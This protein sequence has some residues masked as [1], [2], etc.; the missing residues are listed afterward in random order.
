MPSVA[1]PGNYGPFT[2]YRHR[3]TDYLNEAALAGLSLETA[4]DWYIDDAK[5]LAT[6]PPEGQQVS[7]S[8]ITPCYTCI[9]PAGVHCRRFGDHSIIDLADGTR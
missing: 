3:Y 7:R 9:L 2:Y 5:P 1:I 4:A 8:A 6:V